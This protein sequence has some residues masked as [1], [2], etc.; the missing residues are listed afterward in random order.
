MSAASYFCHYS[1]K[2]S[3][4]NHF[5][6]NHLHGFVVKVLFLYKCTVFLIWNRTFEQGRFH[7]M[8]APAGQGAEQDRAE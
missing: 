4:S 1:T 3:S 7:G 8:P 6:Y 5:V 2:P